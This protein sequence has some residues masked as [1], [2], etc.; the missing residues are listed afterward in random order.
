MRASGECGAA[1]VDIRR[2]NRLVPR[3]SA[4]LPEKA[5]F[6][7]S[8]CPFN[9]WLLEI[10]QMSQDT[11]SLLL[12]PLLLDCSCHIPAPWLML[13]SSLHAL[14]Q[15]LMPRQCCSDHDIRMPQNSGPSDTSASCPASPLQLSCLPLLGG[16][17][18]LL[19]CKSPLAQGSIRPALAL[20]GWG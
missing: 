19:L 14:S 10:S 1:W 7:V 6:E 2:M 17:A 18:T 12:P 16:H 15:R 4:R 9:D 20:A 8:H 5:T 3:E 11:T 13:L